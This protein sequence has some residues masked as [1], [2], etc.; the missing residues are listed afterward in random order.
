M[1]LYRRELLTHTA[2]PIY[3]G[4]LVICAVGCYLYFLNQAVVSVVQFKNYQQDVA[5]LQT[6]IA[7]LESSLIEA[8]HVIAAEVTTVAGFTT[9]IDKIYVARPSQSLVVQ[10]R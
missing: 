5:A 4:I 1:K 10:A 8:Q 3:A 9:D 6:R 7:S 2:T